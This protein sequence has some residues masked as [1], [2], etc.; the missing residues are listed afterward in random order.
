[1]RFLSLIR[2]ATAGGAFLVLI[3]GQVH[4]ATVS[5]DDS[6]PGEPPA[7]WI[8]TQTGMG[9]ARWRVQTDAT[10]PSRA[11]VLEQSGTAAF[12]LCVKEEARLKDGFV[13]A[14]FKTLSGKDDQAGGVVW[15]YRDADNYYV[16]RAN[17]LE[18][19]VV[20][21]KVEN[22]KRQALDIIG[23]VGGYGVKEPVAPQQWHTLRVEFVG[24]H[25][26]VRFNGKVLFEVEDATF[27][28][29]GLVGV[30]TKADSVTRFDDFTFAAR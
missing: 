2:T 21:Y 24:T 26:K 9:T 1:M 4:A 29:A 25:F 28:Q 12:P 30:W 17:A 18:N 23:R 7:G 14:K 13:E 6:K 5:W 19:N 27:S 16:C 8:C 10:A 20:L 3:C 15:R 22:G 11:N